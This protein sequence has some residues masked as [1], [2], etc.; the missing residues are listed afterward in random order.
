MSPRRINTL[1]GEWRKQMKL[2]TAVLLAAASVVAVAQDMDLTPPKEMGNIAWMQG[3][4]TGVEKYTM[5]DG[6]TSDGTSIVHCASAIGGRFQQSTH[7]MKMQGMEFA[8]MML[9]SYDSAKK[10]YVAWWFDQASSSDMKAWGD[11]NGNTLIFVSEPT[12]MPGMPEKVVMRMTFT[13]VS[14][15]KMTLVIDQKA[16]DKW[17]KFLDGTYTKKPN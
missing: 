16:G 7:Q 4:W 13:K 10:K 8:G 12:E 15:T 9:V 17:Q 6:S 11:L 1:E 3:H 5:P 14:D 2:I